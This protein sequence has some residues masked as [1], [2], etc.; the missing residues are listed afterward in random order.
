VPN[1]RLAVLETD[2]CSAQPVTEGVLQL[3]HPQVPE[4]IGA[5]SS[6]LRFIALCSPFFTSRFGTTKIDVYSSGS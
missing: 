2:P 6:E 1:K 5:G 3:V 4:P